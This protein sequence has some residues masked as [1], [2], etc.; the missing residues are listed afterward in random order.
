MYQK[1]PATRFL[2]QSSLWYSSAN[3]Q[4][5]LTQSPLT[6]YKNMSEFLTELAK[7]C[8]TIERSLQKLFRQKIANWTMQPWSA[9]K[10]ASLSKVTAGM[11]T[12]TAHVVGESHRVSELLITIIIIENDF[13]DN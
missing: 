1:G 9:G 2:Q 12:R 10:D 7:I 11:R 4:L 6:M 13:N 8:G 3:S 5:S